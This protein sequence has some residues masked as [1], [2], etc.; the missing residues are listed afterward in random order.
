M[1]DINSVMAINI[2]NIYKPLQYSM[3]DN[4]PD[5]IQNAIVFILREENMCALASLSQT[6]QS[7]HTITRKIEQDQTLR[8]YY[9]M[10]CRSMV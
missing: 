4:I 1:F 8:E 5:D 10:I 3:L 6:C 2:S 9:D 7:L